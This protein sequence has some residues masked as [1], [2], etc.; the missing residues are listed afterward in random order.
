MPYFNLE[1]GKTLGRNYYIVEFLGSGWEGEVYKVEERRTG[2]IRAAKIFYEGRRLKD[3]QLQRYAKKLY[4]LRHCP[5]ITQYHHRDFARVGRQSVEILISDFAEGEMLSTFLDRQPRKKL[6]SFEALHLLYALAA[7]VERI[8]H[9]GE[10]HGD[11]HSNNIMVRRRGLEFKV[12]LLDFFDLGRSGKEKIQFD[13]I[14]MI[15]ILY[16]AI[17][18]MKEYKKVGPE[19]RKIILGRKHSLIGQHYKNATQLKA[20]LENLKW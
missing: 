6:P 17:G 14:D 7:G 3:R 12:H 1:P 19:I 4:R 18:G 5:I 20:A 10:Y 13:V 2:I 8:H 11:I 9:L 16:E 15:S